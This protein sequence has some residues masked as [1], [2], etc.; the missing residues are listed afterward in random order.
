MIFPIGDDQVKGGSK[1]IFSYSFIAINILVFVLLQLGNEA[2]TYANSAVP[3]EITTGTDLITQQGQIPHF[4]G[5]TPIY[6]TLLCSI[7]MHGSWMHLIGNMVFLWVFADNI[8]STVGSRRFVIFYLLGG[9]AASLSHIATD[10]M[11]VMPSLGASGAIA[12]CLGAY[13]VMFPKSKVKVLF[14]IKIFAVPAFLFLGFWIV[15]QVISGMGS[16]GGDSQGIAWF[17][18][19]GGFAFGV[20]GG[21]F[22]RFRYP[23]V[24]QVHAEYSPVEVVATRY[25]NK[26][27]TNRF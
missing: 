19:I 7:L 3:Y 15:Q 5:P 4:P 10:S 1:P 8:E 27:I 22:F 18:H 11:S 21:L 14:F 25:N 9:L 2:F 26:G 23:K 24:E 20:I 6:L 13:L 16:L 17:A 12:A